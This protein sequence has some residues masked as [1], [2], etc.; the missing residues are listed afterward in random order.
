M[1]KKKPAEAAPA[2]T[3][4]VLRTCN[5][6]STSTNGF[7][8]PAVGEKA[9]C[10]DW[11]ANNECGNGLHGW[12]FGQG[13][14]GT[15]PNTGADA[16]WLVVEVVSDSI[17][18]LGGKCKFPEALVRFKGDRKRATD[19]LRA[20][21][22]RS[23][24]CAV[25]G[26][27]I[28][29]GDHAAGEVGALGTLT[30]GNGSTLTG[31]NGSTLTGGNGSTLTGGNGSTLTGGNGSTLTGGNDSTLT[32]GNGS[33][34]TGGY[35]STLTGGNDSTLTGGNGSTLTG[36]NGST[37]TGGNDSTLTGGNDSTLTGGNDST[38]TGG[39]GSTLVFAWWD[40]ANRRR[41]IVVAEVGID[42]IEANVAY[43]LDANHKPAKVQS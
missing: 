26:A 37:L 8:W 15:A 14:H 43:K 17:I 12:L 21:E 7:V 22:P 6:D 31:G 19:F 35:D 1:A 30:G 2:A 28:E 10:P 9:I 39:N 16:L 25:I 13:D 23:L 29:V 3:S 20:N 32:G 27:S 24:T 41:R 34:L 5:A 36:G 33:T 42:G 18:M 4:L 38:L 11:K 40:S